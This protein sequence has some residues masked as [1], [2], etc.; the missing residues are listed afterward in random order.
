[1]ETDGSPEAAASNP[2][3]KPD[4]EGSVHVPPLIHLTEEQEKLEN[5]DPEEEI[6]Y[7]IRMGEERKRTHLP[8]LAHVRISR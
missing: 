5:V 3:G 7:G 2:F 4:V 6:E 8:R 1:L